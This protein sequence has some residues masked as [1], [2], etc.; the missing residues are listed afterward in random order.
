MSAL[1]VNSGSA[2][3]AYATQLAQTSTLQRSLSSLGAAI[4]N[5]DLTSA[6]S[7]LTAFIKANPQYASTSTSGSQT[8][9]PI[10]QDFQT[11]ATAV[12][13]NQVDAAKNAWTQIKTDLA[14]SGVAIN[15]GTSTTTELLAQ[16]QASV[17]EQIINDILGT[18][19]GDS[20]S[21]ATILGQDG[22]SSNGTGLSSSLLSEWLTYQQSGATTSA[23]AANNAG[24]NLDTEV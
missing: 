8:E 9:D 10:N 22:D 15:G 24:T 17:S 14:N 20:S 3:I 12:S 1:S 19:S 21:L 7:I 23:T 16:N 18:G 11:L 5:G 2:S 13:N 6:N 4:Q